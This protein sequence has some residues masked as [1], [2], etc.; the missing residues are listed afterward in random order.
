MTNILVTGSKGQLG[1]SL[2]EISKNYKKCTFIF[3]DV[4]TLDITEKTDILGFFKKNNFDYCINCAAYTAV[5]KAEIEAELCYKINAEAV[6]NLAEACFMTNCK[7]IQISTDF[8]F[9]G[10][11]KEPYL[12]NDRPNPINVYG[13]SKHKGEEYVQQLLN[14]FFIIRTSW[15]YSKHRHN[16]VK[17]MLR[18]GSERDQLN[19]VSDQHGSPTYAVDLA[20]FILQII[21]DKLK[22]FGIYHYSNI[23]SISWF[24]F[25]KR[26]IELSDY[27][28]K[29][30][31]IGSKEYETEALRP[32]YSVMN[33]NKSQSVIKET[34]PIWDESLKR[35]LKEMAL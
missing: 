31:P 1:N 23:G 27:E 11:K 30:L 7:L 2:Q 21:E 24:D 18:L 22:A 17:T 32:Q 20:E 9:D 25:A 6:K 13:A 3:T 34:I 10:Q 5:D 19:V 28:T 35:C 29:V 15:V 14:D 33:T 12:E 4:D 26:I 8:I 16:F